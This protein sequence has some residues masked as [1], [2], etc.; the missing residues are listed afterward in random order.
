MGKILYKNRGKVFEK[1]S[2][3]IDAMNQELAA[4]HKEVISNLESVQG[5]LLRLNR[6]IQAEGRF[7]ILKRDKSYK[8][9]DYFEEAKKM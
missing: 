8:I 9:K 6:S 1:I 4:I 3:L 7:G 5:V 2:S